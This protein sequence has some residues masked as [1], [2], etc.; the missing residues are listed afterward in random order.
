MRSVST[1][2]RTR[3]HLSPY[4]V[5]ARGPTV[6]S[7]PF[8][9]GVRHSSCVATASSASSSDLHRHH[10]R[11][12]G[13]PADFDGRTFSSATC[14]TR[15][16][17]SLNAITL[18][19]SLNRG[20]L[21]ANDDVSFGRSL[22]TAPTGDDESID[23]TN[24]NSSSKEERLKQL[25]SKYSS[26][27]QTT[28][29]YNEAIA[30]YAEIGELA[31]AEELL[32]EMEQ[33]AKQ[34]SS[35]GSTDGNSA[36]AM[37][38]IDSYTAVI[39]S[40][41][42]Y[43][44]ELDAK[45]KGRELRSG[46]VRAAERIDAILQRMERATSSPDDT[47]TKTTTKGAPSSHHYDAAVT[48]WSRC[49][50]K[51]P[52][53]ALRGIPQRAQAVLGRME[54]LSLDRSSGV[55]PTVETYNK[56]IE[57]WSNST[58]EYSFAPLAQAVYDRMDH[59]PAAH[60]DIQPNDRTIRTMIRCWTRS[61]LKNAAFHATGHLMRLQELTE[62]GA[63]DM[64]PTLDDYLTVFKCWS[65]S[66]DKHAARRAQTVLKQMER[67]YQKRISDCRPT[68]SCYRYVLIAMSN[69]KLSG[70]G[71][72]ADELMN[73]MEDR[74]MVVDSG[75]FAATIKVWSNSACHKDTEDAAADADRADEALQQMKDMYHR[76]SQIVV[77]ANTSNYNDVLCAYAACQRDDAAGW[78]AEEL[79]EEMIKLAGEGDSDVA[80]DAMSYVFTM[81]VL[82]QSTLPNKVAKSMKLLKSIAGDGSNAS[83]NTTSAVVKPIVDCFHAMIKVCSSVENARDDEKNRALRA[84]IK[85]VKMLKD[86]RS[87]ECKPNAETYKLLIEACGKLIRAGSEQ[88]KALETVFNNCCR[89]GLVDDRVLRQFKK[90]APFDLYQSKILLN[91]K[92]SVDGDG[93]VLPE[94]WSMNIGH[95]VRTAEGRRP[96]PLS[97]DV[98]FVVTQSM[99]NYKMRRLRSRKNQ[100]LL[101]GGRS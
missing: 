92:S 88:Q 99:A 38:D 84:A 33:K 8:T 54:A 67:L 10:N 9:F 79:L 34:S 39:D 20:L 46:I 94:D 95:R 52:I 83:E 26:G 96:Q 64:S 18:F 51:G 23:A 6:T 11:H 93:M 80:P 17:G 43:Q 77:K 69:S 2:I 35:R 81:N 30:G 85:T 72:S 32:S 29:E 86:R 65:K 45:E 28:G 76:S 70:L 63:E 24:N 78:R 62:K 19:N 90:T 44:I 57:A 14:S 41:L 66:D 100:H 7:S 4:P 12:S 49:V 25:N 89:D 48:A 50:S 31:K 74:L 40:Y 3:L 59:G 1:R 61:D 5:A 68:V 13:V 82:A 55:S 87:E 60:L 71:P 21:H 91:A 98:G 75:C 37:P 58:N 36:I 56:V 27:P 73:R 101:R 53:W 22:S 47:T 16:C 42:T 97:P 15:P